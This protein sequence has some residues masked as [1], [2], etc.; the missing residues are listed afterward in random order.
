MLFSLVVISVISFALSYLGSA[1][2]LVLG[3]LRV[4]LLVYVLGSVTVGTSTS[5]AISTAATLAGLIPHLRGRRVSF[6][7]FAAVGVPSAIAAHFSSRYAGSIDPQ[8]LK[9]AIAITLLAAGVQLLLRSK[10]ATSA[11][12]TRAAEERRSR[13]AFSTLGL[14]VLVGAILGAV[15]GLV[16]LLLGSLR[17]PAMLRLVRVRPAVAVGTNVAIGAATGLAGGLTSALHGRVDLPTF[18]V[19]TPLTLLGA[20]LGAQK[21]GTLESAV[22]VRWI[23]YA[24]IPTAF[25]M[26]VEVR[27]DP[28][29][30]GAPAAHHTVQASKGAPISRPL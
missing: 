24:L 27:F 17:L 18:A 8:L 9:C 13:P 19:V 10:K 5:L 30:A 25:I 29:A 6:S 28:R 22:L 23:G 7:L 15:S 20:Y 21:A 16:G 4:V 12:G 14:E 11:D 3:Q 2:G 26:F 1:V